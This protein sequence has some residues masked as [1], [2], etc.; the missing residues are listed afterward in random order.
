M[1]RK[2]KEKNDKV[3]SEIKTKLLKKKKIQGRTDTISKDR[4]DRK[5]KSNKIQSE[6]ERGTKDYI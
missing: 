5:R 4:E 2:E 6:I 3:I 1:L